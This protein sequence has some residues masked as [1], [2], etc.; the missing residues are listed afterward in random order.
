MESARYF[1]LIWTKIQMCRQILVKLQCKD[2]WKSVKRY[3]KCDMRRDRY[4]EANRHIFVNFSCKNFY[5]GSETC[6]LTHDL[7][8]P[9]FWWPLAM[10]K[11]AA[12]VTTTQRSYCEAET[13]DTSLPGTITSRGKDASGPVPPL[14]QCTDPTSQDLWSLCC[15]GTPPA[16]GLPWETERVWFNTTKTVA[17]N[18]LK[19]T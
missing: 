3:S 9:W 16:L 1:H 19:H 7:F 17:F 14:G 8:S 2:D 5:S 15:S 13:D 11:Q 4:G 12:N 18:S 6:I 10:Q